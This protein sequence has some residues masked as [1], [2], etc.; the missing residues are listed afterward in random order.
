MTITLPLVLVGLAV[1]FAAAVGVGV[2]L[3]RRRFHRTGG[4][5]GHDESLGADG[6]SGAVGFVGGAAAFL[7]GVLMLTSLDHYNATKTIVAEEAL[8]YSSAFESTDGLPPADQS[9]IQRDL[10]C[11]MRSVATKSWAAAEADDLTGSDNTH[12]WRR[13]AATHANATDPVTKAQEDS[14]QN[15]KGALLTASDRGQQRLLA[16][17]S[18]LPVALWILVF[19]SIFVLTAFLTALLI[20]HPSRTL[21]LAGLGAVL[22]VSAAMLWTLITF[23]QPFT[24]GDA[25]Y[26][27]PRALEAVM[28]RLE[29][30]YPEADWGPCETLPRP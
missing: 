6:M 24:Q 22:T 8:A 25:V 26:I 9:A 27:S 29:G 14:L 1:V 10:I 4:G 19:V 12:A 2:L 21:A 16:A 23:D 28:V 15:L 18:D 20:S 3:H 13:R 17:R 5:T 7:L 11:L 30:T